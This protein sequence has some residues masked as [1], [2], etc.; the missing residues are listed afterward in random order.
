[1][2]PR[3]WHRP[4]LSPEEERAL[5]ARIAAGGP[6][7]LAARNLLVEAY[8][9]LAWRVA[10]RY[11]GRGLEYADLRG[12]A[13]LG[14][15]RAAEVY[16]PALGTEGTM[17]FL[18]IA[19]ATVRGAILPGLWDGRGTIRL[20]RWLTSLRNRV[21]RGEVD[22]AGLPPE[23]RTSLAAAEAARGV[24]GVGGRWP[25]RGPAADPMETIP[26]PEDDSA[27]DAEDW[28]LVVR[29]LGRLDGCWRAV[30][31][32]RYGLDG[33]PPRP[34]RQV[35]AE[36]GVHRSRVYVIEAVALAR[37]RRW[38]DEGTA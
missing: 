5:A 17:A 32:A 29:L 12:L 9:P 28:A 11:R 30:L 3:S 18:P 1:M 25:R 16:D 26:A 27:Y 23:T 33:S 6:D 21:R 34:A 35:A 13:V 36:L 7:G 2:S 20:P 38:A 24:R 22:P 4:R 15:I 8:L 37:L 19:A 10:R 14:L 31:V